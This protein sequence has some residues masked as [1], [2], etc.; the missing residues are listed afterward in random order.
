[1]FRFMLDLCCFPV[2]M[3]AALFYGAGYE[4]ALWPML[5]TGFGILLSIVSLHVER[6][7]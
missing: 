2:F 6:M 4:K 1:M 3:S 7:K 5:L